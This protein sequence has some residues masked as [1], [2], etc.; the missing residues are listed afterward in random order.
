MATGTVTDI[1][2]APTVTTP[3]GTPGR[4]LTRAAS[5]RQLA[6]NIT[7]KAAPPSTNAQN[8]ATAKRGGPERPGLGTLMGTQTSPWA[9]E[10]D[11]RQCPRRTLSTASNGPS[12]Y[13]DDFNCLAG[14]LRWDVIV[15]AAGADT[16][17]QYPALAAA[18]AFLVERQ[19][20]H[21]FF[22]CRWPGLRQPK[23]V[24]QPG[25]AARICRGE[26]V[27]PLRDL[28]RGAHADG[29]RS[30]VQQDAVA[31]AGFQGVADRVAVVEQ[32]AVARFALVALDDVG[33]ELDRTGHDRRQL[34]RV[35]WPEPWDQILQV[36]KQIGVEDHGHF[37]YFGHAATECARR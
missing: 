37:G 2:P 14:Y 3:I 17:G 10:I 26:H 9:A 21:D 18:G 23:A 5:A 15:H 32:H 35:V 29:D 4:S 30:T 11:Y 28:G 16:F 25:L 22:S 6:M 36:G 12:R 20:F 33:F 1:G 8:A 13:R 24:Q 7:P 31:G 19:T 27:E 34:I